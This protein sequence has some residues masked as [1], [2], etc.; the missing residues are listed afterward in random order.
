MI[1]AVDINIQTW[2]EKLQAVGKNAF[3]L[4]TL[5]RESL[6]YTGCRA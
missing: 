5:E 4:E 2:I 3:S 1:G 6:S